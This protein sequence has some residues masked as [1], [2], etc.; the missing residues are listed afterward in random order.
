M[1]LVRLT[2]AAAAL[3]TFAGIAAAKPLAR[4]QAGLLPVLTIGRI[5]GGPSSLDPAKGDQTIADLG[6]ETL[7]RL[8]SAGQVRPWLA[9][10]VTQ[11]GPTTLVYH[12]RHDVRFWDGNELTS[13]DVVSSLNYE[14]RTGSGVSWAYTAV[15]SIRP[16]GRYAVTVTLKH[17]SL[18]WPYETALFGTLIWEKRFQDAHRAT[19]GHPGTLVMGTGPYMFD[20]FD[21]TR[22]VELSANP[23]W[24]GGAVPAQ[25]LKVMFFANEDGEALAFRAGAID[26]SGFY[27]GDPRSFARTSGAHLQ[28]AHSSI[29]NYVFSMN[30]HQ[31]PWSDIHV[32]RAV[33]YALDRSDFI[34][35]HGGYASPVYTLIPP[36]ALQ[37]LASPARVRSLLKSVPLYAFDLAKAKQELAQSAYPN[38]FSATIDEPVDQSNLATIG[39]AVAGDLA[40]IGIK[41][42]IHGVQ[43]GAWFGELTGP[44]AKR[45]ANLIEGGASSPAPSG[46][47]Y[48]L[49]SWNTAAGGFNTAVYT[50]KDV[51]GLLRAGDSATKARAFGIY[52]RLVERLQTD[53]PYVNLIL[54][55]NT[56][57]LSP[58]LTLRGGLGP[59]TFFTGSWLADIRPR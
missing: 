4:P 24:W 9:Q 40:K 25:R 49:G 8:G 30:T 51:D 14:R 47:D 52:A 41:I 57:A 50:P 12:L 7:M 33:A 27:I 36:A 29:D 54:V 59:Y 20:S 35:A 1:N 45:P 44:V 3:A 23:H 32:R 43:S 19:F 46:N 6:L 16:S 11:P 2:A 22:G 31:A 56:L 15:K 39:Q 28:V 18:D 17:P 48:W 38:G 5:G 42:T 58:K 26:A 53:V 55:D 21:P 10:A 37:T 34:A 13:A